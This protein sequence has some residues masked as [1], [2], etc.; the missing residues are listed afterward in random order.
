MKAAIEFLRSSSWL[1]QASLSKEP[2][3]SDLR[4]QERSVFLQQPNH[5]NDVTATPFQRGQTM[6]KWQ[7]KCSS[8]WRTSKDPVPAHLTAL[9]ISANSATG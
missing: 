3:S 9:Q 4:I 8:P 5:L 1:S 2:S 7:T 6:K